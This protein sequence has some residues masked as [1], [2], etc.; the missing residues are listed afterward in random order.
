MLLMVQ[1]DNSILISMIAINL[2]LIG[3]TSLAETK[4]VLGIDY[5]KFLINRYR[6]FSSKMKLKYW[7]LSFLLINGIATICLAWND[8]M[9]VSTII[10]ISLSLCIVTLLLYFFFFILTV[11]RNVKHQIF[12][13]VFSCLYTSINVDKNGRKREHSHFDK[14]LDINDGMPTPKQFKENVVRYFDEDSIDVEEVFSEVFGPKSF[15]Y[16]PKKHQKII[17][18]F[19]KDYNRNSGVSVREMTIVGEYI[20]NPYVYR[21]IDGNIDISHEFFRFFRNSKLQDRWALTM[22]NLAMVKDNYNFISF[23]NIVRILGNVSLFGTTDEIKRYKFF[24]FITNEYIHNADIE[25]LSKYNE[26]RGGNEASVHSLATS[27]TVDF[28]EVEYVFLQNY[29]QLMYAGISL[30]LEQKTFRVMDEFI[31]NSRK[32]IGE[33][34][35]LTK[36]Q[37]ENCLKECAKVIVGFDEKLIFVESKI[38]ECN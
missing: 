28:H 26:Q 27:N 7:L 35:I 31:V 5:G 33:K 38:L 11:N 24:V 25:M 10:S 14:M 6:L 17:K 32:M 1:F 15:L 30:A 23:S 22:Y 4:K 8:V 34:T 16:N 13:D 19:M 36:E 2:T 37:K 12:I 18:T 9:W 20:K 3:L 29:F 21:N